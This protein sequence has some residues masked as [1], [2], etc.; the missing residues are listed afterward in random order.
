MSQRAYGTSF[1]TF[2]DGASD[3]YAD[4]AYNTILDFNQ[5]GSIALGP[6]TVADTTFGGVKYTVNPTVF[7]GYTGQTETVTLTFD[8][9]SAFHV[10]SN[11]GDST[12][13][14]TLGSLFT[15]STQGWKV[16]IATTDASSVAYPYAKGDTIKYYITQATS[17]IPI[18]N[19]F[20]WLDQT[21]YPLGLTL[22]PPTS[23]T[24]NGKR[25]TLMNKQAQANVITCSNGFN[26][27][28][29]SGTITFGAGALTKASLLAY[30]GV[31]YAD[32]TVG[33][34]IA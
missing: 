27:K 22:N 1:Q 34:T 2:G 32:A 24:D 20:I 33:V 7:K 30:Q 3:L 19:G 28:G 31:W 26:G 14:G 4:V 21:N 25:L 15:D 23:G 17:T 12:G 13:S 10:S 18:S 29:S 8:S 16:Q 11:V 6:V 5:L 9:T